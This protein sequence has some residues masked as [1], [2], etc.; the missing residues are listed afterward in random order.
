M[1]E[2]ENLGFTIANE[3]F[4]SADYKLR[5]GAHISVEDV[6]LYDFIKMHFPELSNF[7]RRYEAALMEGAEGYYYLVSQGATFGQR[8]LSKS[9]MLVGLTIAH[10]YRDPE[11]RVRGTGQLSV[12]QVISRLETLKSE[13]DIAR[14]VTES[15]VKADLH[16]SR[17]REA[18][19]DAVKKLAA[20][21]FLHLLDPSGCAFR[22]RRPIHRF[23]QFVSQLDST[24]DH[25]ANGA[26]HEER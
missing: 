10:L 13:E 1:N 11:N 4:P 9:E 26:D 5:R 2:N 8:Q 15:K 17:V 21:N 3:Q 7:Y 12:E 24:A 22:C 16:P 19:L 20:L 23:D 18:T 25:E 6:E 14:L